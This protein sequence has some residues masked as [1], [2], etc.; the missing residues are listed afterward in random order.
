MGRSCFLPILERERKRYTRALR[1][2][3]GVDDVA[4]HAPTTD[5]MVACARNM[6]DNT[7]YCR[8]VQEVPEDGLALRSIPVLIGTSLSVSP[9]N[10][11]ANHGVGSSVASVADAAGQEAHPTREGHLASSSVPPSIARFLH[12]ASSVVSTGRFVA[13]TRSR[14][15]SPPIFSDPLRAPDHFESQS[16][17][18]SAFPPGILGVPVTWADSVSGPTYE[19]PRY[20][21]IGPSDPGFV[22]RNRVLHLINADTNVVI[23]RRNHGV[24]RSRPFCTVIE[25]EYETSGITQT[26]ILLAANVLVHPTFTEEVNPNMMYVGDNSEHRLLDRLDVFIAPHHYGVSLRNYRP[27]NLQESAF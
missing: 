3:G 17:G 15:P 25:A 22:Q 24:C 9:P 5:P 11:P 19:T 21:I 18:L 8:A 27:P 7:V 13:S 26:R 6:L 16:A 2:P 1:D 10:T 14:S 4:F 12:L 23:L 20:A